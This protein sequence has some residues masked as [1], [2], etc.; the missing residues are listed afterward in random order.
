M[1]Q[2]AIPETKKFNK[3]LIFFLISIVKSH[4]NPIYLMYSCT[5]EFRSFNWPMYDTEEIPQTN[6][7]KRY[8][9]ESRELA[10][11]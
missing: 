9:N 8:F 2:N 5:T 3:L 11:F 10:F 7:Q 4:I 6:M 1:T